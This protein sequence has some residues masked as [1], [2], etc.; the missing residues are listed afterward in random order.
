MCRIKPA[1]NK[2]DVKVYLTVYMYYVSPESPEIANP[3][4]LIELMTTGVLG[5]AAIMFVGL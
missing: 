5:K 4:R 2:Q 1:L 3:L